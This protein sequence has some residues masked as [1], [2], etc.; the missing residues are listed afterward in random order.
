MAPNHLPV[1]RAAWWK[2]A[3]ANSASQHTRY[4]S[5]GLNTM[6]IFVGSDR[7]SLCGDPKPI[8]STNKCIDT[9]HSASMY[10]ESWQRIFL[11]FFAGFLAVLVCFLALLYCFS[12]D[13]KWSNHWGIIYEQWLQLPYTTITVRC[14]GRQILCQESQFMWNCSDDGQRMSAH[15]ERNIVQIIS[16]V[17][18]CSDYQHAGLLESSKDQWAAPFLAYFSPPTRDIQ[19]CKYRKKR[20]ML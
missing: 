20:W 12:I 9:C 3:T 18:H 14:Q 6:I 17:Q 16:I 2:G 8:W 7:K 10:Q 1:D 4:L 15:D 5:S 13:E 11:P 19:F